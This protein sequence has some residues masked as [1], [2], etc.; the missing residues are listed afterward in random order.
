MYIKSDFVI[1]NCI[2]PK[3]T[4]AYKLQFIDSNNLNNLRYFNQ[5]REE[6]K[7]ALKPY[8]MDIGV[9]LINLLYL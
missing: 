9:K 1:V 3:T 8:I 5:L 2:F 4:L 6:E 7:I